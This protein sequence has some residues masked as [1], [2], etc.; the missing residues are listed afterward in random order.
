MEGDDP[1]PLL[2]TDEATSG[3]LCPV[4]GS[5]VQARDELTVVNPEQGHEDDLC[6]GVSFI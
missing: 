6:T 1:S 3:V 2:S 4:L 5:P